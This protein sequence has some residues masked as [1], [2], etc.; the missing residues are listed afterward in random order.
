M[1]EV[2]RLVAMVAL[3]VTVTAHVSAGPQA[4]AAP[5]RDAAKD[6]RAEAL[7]EAAR[8]GDAAAVK[9]LLDAGVDVNTPF[10]YGATALSYAC[11]RGHLEVVRVL[12]ERGADAN[13]EGHLLRRHAAVV[14]VE[15]G[16]DA[17]A[18]ARADSRAAAEARRARPGSR[19]DLGHPRGRRR[20]GARSSSTTAASPPRR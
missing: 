13:V 1:R 16:A 10:R 6:G 12:L 4:T 14:G 15:P 11:D 7:W 17:E 9:T 2:R 8:K 19:P 3:G 18:R 20:D 5:P